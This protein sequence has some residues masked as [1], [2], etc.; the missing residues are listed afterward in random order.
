MHSKNGS[1]GLNY[2][3]LLSDNNNMTTNELNVSVLYISIFTEKYMNKR[4]RKST[5]ISKGR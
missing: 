1:S 5:Q 3:I 2:L 4:I